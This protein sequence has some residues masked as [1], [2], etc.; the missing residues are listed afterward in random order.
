MYDL[1]ANHFLLLIFSK[2]RTIQKAT[3]IIVNKINSKREIKK[4]INIKKFPKDLTNMTPLELIEEMRKTLSLYELVVF[5]MKAIDKYTLQDI[6]NKF[7][8]NLSVLENDYSYIIKKLQ[9]G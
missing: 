1:F 3:T 2:K 6:A 5:N 7:S 8:I 9:Y 4:L